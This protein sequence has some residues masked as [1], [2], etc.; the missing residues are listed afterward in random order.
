M[1]HVTDFVKPHHILCYA[2]THYISLSVPIVGTTCFTG[3]H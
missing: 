1:W 3:T 2:Y